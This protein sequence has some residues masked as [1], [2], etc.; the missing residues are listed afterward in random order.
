[1]ITYEV[2]DR[3]EYRLILILDGDRG[4]GSILIP[5]DDLEFLEKEIKQLVEK[6]NGDR[7]SRT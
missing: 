1:M 5:K 6:W 3:W 7:E 2:R 4:M